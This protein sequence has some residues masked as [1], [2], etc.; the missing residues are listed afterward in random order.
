MIEST[1]MQVKFM[2]N[3]FTGY[4]VGLLL[5]LTFLGITYSHGN[6]I[7]STIKK[8]AN[9]EIPSLIAASNLKKD[10]QSQTIALYALYASNDENAYQKQF[11]H[12]KSAILIDASKLQSLLG[13]G[14]FTRSLDSKILAREE[15]ANKFVEIMRK[16]EVDWDAA[17]S[18]L[19]D[20]SEDA[21]KN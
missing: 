14:E 15:K 19:S 13:V 4:I 5:L 16:P 10:F 8:L 2:Q 7:D 11:I 20:F 3:L 21:Q 18:S 17:R 1:T 6:K 12:T 9:S